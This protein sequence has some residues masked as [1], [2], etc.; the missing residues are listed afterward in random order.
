MLALAIALFKDAA[1]SAG[2][3]ARMADKPLPEMLTLLSN[4]DIPLTTT[5][6]EEAAED[7]AVAREWLQQQALR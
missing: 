3:A 5:D 6:A 7:M 1:I 2:S 4:L